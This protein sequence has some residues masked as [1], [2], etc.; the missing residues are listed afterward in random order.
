MLKIYKDSNVKVVTQ[1]AYKDFYEHLGYKIFE[2]KPLK[3]EIEVRDKEIKE[4]QTT[5]ENKPNKVNY[6]RK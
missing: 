1:G 2:E 3:K 5:K 4:N 6:S